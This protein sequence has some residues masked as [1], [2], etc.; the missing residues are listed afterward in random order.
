MRASGL[1]RRKAYVGTPLC[2][3]NRACLLRSQ[4]QHNHGITANE[5][6]FHEFR[7][8]L[9]RSTLATWLKAAGYQTGYFGKYLNGYDRTLY[10]PPGWDR[11]WGWLGTYYSPDVY[12]VND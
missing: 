3:P 10:V 5:E 2:G 1:L 6:C 8:R 7:Q 12:E 9:D 4:H 11:W